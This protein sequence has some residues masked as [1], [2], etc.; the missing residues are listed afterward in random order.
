MKNEL[1]IAEMAKL[2]FDNQYDGF[3][4]GSVWLVNNRGT[5]L[6]THRWQHRDYLHSHDDVQRVIDEMD[7]VAVWNCV[8]HL[9]APTHEMWIH[10]LMKATPSQKCEAI[11]KAYG[12]WEGE[13]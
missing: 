10:D 7:R 8:E 12:K 1:I 5:E 11:L 4:G 9:S 6:E 2:E 3:K 13:L